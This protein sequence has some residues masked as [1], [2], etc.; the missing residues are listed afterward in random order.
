MKIKLIT[1]KQQK[2]YE[3]Q[4]I[5]NELAHWK[6][7][8]REDNSEAQLNHITNMV[9]KYTKKLE[10]ITAEIEKYFIHMED[11]YGTDN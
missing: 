6:L 8:L 2:F 9:F 3:L 1:F 11:N 7:K 4:S 10:D 5:K